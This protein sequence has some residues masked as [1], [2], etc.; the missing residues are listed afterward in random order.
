MI[1]TL[2]W[3]AFS[4]CSPVATKPSDNG[5]GLS[6]LH[7]QKL[8]QSIINQWYN[9]FSLPVLR[10]SR[11]VKLKQWFLWIFKK[12]KT[13]KQSLPWY[14]QNYR[15]ILQSKE[16]NTN[17]ILTSSL[18]ARDKVLDK[19]STASGTNRLVSCTYAYKHVQ[20]YRPVKI[21]TEDGEGNTITAHQPLACYNISKI[22]NIALR[23]HL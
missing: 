1:S 4:P 8:W 11:S 16:E 17:L 6:V 19:K 3:P 12:C 10:A 5:L 22:L 23:Q 7:Y 13:G 9:T 14:L 21:T 2:T 20:I 15:L 18:Q